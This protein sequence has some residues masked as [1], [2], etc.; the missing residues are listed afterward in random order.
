MSGVVHRWELTTL[1]VHV[2][3]EGKGKRTGEASIF[4]EYV[5]TQDHDW[6]DATF[7][8]VDYAKG[9]REGPASTAIPTAPPSKA[10]PPHSLAIA[11]LTPKAKQRAKP[12]SVEADYVSDDP[13]DDPI[14][15]AD[16]PS[17]PEGEPF[18]D[19]AED[20]A[21]NTKTFKGGIAY[22]KT[23]LWAAYKDSGKQTEQLPTP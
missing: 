7:E 13:Y 20:T 11:Q 8:M 1:L 17:D 18:P 2:L 3:L 14:L 4:Y 6:Q 16:P 19:Q 5:P 10:A 15:F 22:G 12:T 23:G 21:V 9:L